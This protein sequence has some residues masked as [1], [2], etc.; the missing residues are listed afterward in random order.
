MIERI[1]KRG[2]ASG[3]ADDNLRTARARIETFRA[4]G[5]PTLRWLREHKVPIVE[6]DASGSPD[7]VWAQLLTIGRLMRSAVSLQNSFM[8]TP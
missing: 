7:E 3:R 6:L 4:Q 5:E 2:L 8:S 1:L